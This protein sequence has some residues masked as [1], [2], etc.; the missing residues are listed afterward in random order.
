MPANLAWPAQASPLALDPADPRLA[1]MADFLILH[2]PV[3]GQ[4]WQAQV[5]PGADATTLQGSVDAWGHNKTELEFS[6][7]ADTGLVRRIALSKPIAT[8][9]ALTL[10]FLQISGL[11][12]HC[13]AE[14]KVLKGAAVA[15]YTGGMSGLLTLGQQ[16]VAFE[17]SG[18]GLPAYN[19]EIDFMAPSNVAIHPL[20]L[21]DLAAF[22]GLTNNPHSDLQ[23]LPAGLQSADAISLKRMRARI[24][25]ANA[26]K[27]TFVEVT[28]GFLGDASWPLIPGFHFLEMGGLEATLAVE[29]PLDSDYR[30]PRV[31]VRGLVTFDGVGVDGSD[32]HIELAA[33]WPDLAAA[34]R[35][36]PRDT[37]ALARLLEHMNVAAGG[38]PEGS[39]A[40]TLTELGFQAEPTMGQKRFSFEASVE[41]AWELELATGKTLAIEWLS[42]QITYQEGESPTMLPRLAG[43]LRI[44][45]VTLSLSAQRETSGWRFAGSTGP[46]QPIA[47]GDWIKKL[48]DHF[49]EVAVPTPIAA[50]EVKNIGL[51]FNTGTKD[52]HFSIQAALPLADLTAAGHPPGPSAIK[53]L[54]LSVS[55]DLLHQGDGFVKRFAGE[56]SL[57]GRKFDL[58]FA[59][60]T[61]APGASGTTLVA[62]YQNRDGDKIGLQ[63]LLAAMGADTTN[64]PALS[65]TLNSAFFGLESQNGV[66]AWRV[67]GINIDGGLNLSNLPLVGKV[68][69]ANET[70]SLEFQALYS[71]RNI[72]TA[73]IEQFVTPVN[74]LLPPGATLLPTTGAGDPVIQKGIDLAT[75]LHL[76]GQVVH[77]DLPVEIDKASGGITTLTGPSVAAPGNPPSNQPVPAAAPVPL[78]QDDL[79]WFSIQRTFGPAHFERI[80]AGLNG[81]QV[82]FALDASLNIAG[83]S[84]SLEGLGLSSPLDQFKPE[85]QL[86][87]IGIEYASGPVAIGGSFLR[88]GEESFAG[89]ALIKTEALTLSAIG[90]YQKVGEAT[91][92]FVYAVLDYPLGGPSFFFVTGLAAGFGYNRSLLLPAIDELPAFPLVAEATAGAGLPKDVINEL[93]KLDR[94]L[95]AD[96]GQYFLAVGVKFTSFKLIDSFALLTVSF[97]KRFEVDVLG[98]STVIVPAPAAQIKGVEPLAKVTMAL[99]ARFIPDEGLLAVDA[100]ITPG[101]FIFSPDCH[102]TGG[103]SFYSWFTGEHEGDFV[104]TLGGY[105]PAF[106]VPPHYPQLPRLGFAWQV[107][108]ELVMKGDV[109]YALTSHAFMAGGHL[110]AT[111]HDGPVRAHFQVGADFLIA[112]QPYRY[113]AEA[114]MHVGGAYDSFLGTISFDLGAHLHLWGPALAGTAELDLYVAT[115]HV[116]F[117]DQTRAAMPYVEWP[118][119]TKAFLPDENAVV[120]V[121]VE[122]GLVQ[123]GDPKSR[124]LGLINPSELRIVTNSLVPLVPGQDAKSNGGSEW[125][126]AVDV[127]PVGI[128]D[129]AS[130]HHV[131]IS[132]LDE[133]KDIDVLAEFRFEPVIKN[134]PAGLWGVP[135]GGKPQVNPQAA[136]VSAVT[137]LRLTPK[138]PPTAPSS[139]TVNSE[140][141]LWEE[142]R[143]PILISQTA[144]EF[145]SD[146]AAAAGS[147]RGLI[148]EMIDHREIVSIRNQYLAA[149]KLDPAEVR[150]GSFSAMMFTAEP[151]LAVL[152]T[153]S[154]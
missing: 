34:G 154:E 70:L 5:A 43:L 78:P 94:Y 129:C 139:K 61:N 85:F 125:V 29:D 115:V 90:A 124:E 116:T 152:G 19:L 13:A 120:S 77:L 74:A 99:L 134:L 53:T 104:L 133:G 114:Y 7:F 113:D 52:F 105:H 80:G 6:W 137:G 89:T 57:G 100:R 83:L 3:S 145:Q 41:N 25:P 64:V 150:L 98:Q 67:A 128:R 42:F 9:D 141:L 95:P 144:C 68:L 126:G 102:L 32:A 20:G 79:K 18:Y 50:A 37:I 111:Y 101:S 81:G 86:R 24:E 71:S 72:Q 107:T 92:L 47:L 82:I 65:I 103:F 11:R 118:D 63:D 31:T 84:L 1:A 10:P 21:G 48:A 130:T 140:S 146:E 132:R 151:R 97:G 119:F 55:L 35:L 110:E 12:Q 38:L 56:V 88:R 60:V 138:K 16:S 46:D 136:M 66:E 143:A 23:W 30:F 122:S 112:W 121:A 131:S 75:S 14:V 44:G 142:A 123:A 87:G 106:V 117:G 2:G 36:R 45:E 73:E 49:G 54:E 51:T 148:A 33:R 76:G 62:V 153:N 69:P 127:A 22:L 93:T 96:V 4:A 17:L 109:Y 149:L 108:P 27:L 135:S 15:T 8:L 59:R 26:H 28:L 58:N 39:R 40:L 147:S 91:S